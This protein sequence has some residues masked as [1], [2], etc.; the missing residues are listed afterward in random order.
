[1]LPVAFISTFDF[2]YINNF[3]CSLVELSGQFIDPVYIGDELILTGEIVDLDEEDALVKCN[4][5]LE[6]LKTGSVA[7]KGAMNVRFSHS[8]KNEKGFSKAQIKSSFTAMIKEPLILQDLRLEDI[9]KKDALLF[10]G[11]DRHHFAHIIRLAD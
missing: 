5:S 7:V 1:M 8:E 10:F 11:L 4:Y 2:F 9:S 3:I 6:K